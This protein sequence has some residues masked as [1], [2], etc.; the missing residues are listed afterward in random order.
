M[1]QIEM[2]KMIFHSNIGQ[3]E[4]EISPYLLRGEQDLVEMDSQNI[5]DSS[6]EEVKNEKVYRCKLCDHKITTLSQ[7]IEM[8]GG[9]RHTF[10]N[11]GG[12]VFHIGCFQNASGCVVVGLPSI[13]WSWFQS[14][15][16][17]VALCEVCSNHKL[18]KSFF[19][20]PCF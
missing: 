8:A 12:K 6:E 3:L 16:W 15:S 11:P 19:F 10:L 14:F 7:Q 2:E 5:E 20:T 4:G 18:T 9:D 13:E 1:Y 17:K